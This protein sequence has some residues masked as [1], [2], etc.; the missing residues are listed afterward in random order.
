MLDLIVQAAQHE[1][2]QPSAVA[3]DPTSGYVYIGLKR[4]QAIGVFH[5]STG[6]RVKTLNLPSRPSQVAINPIQHLVYAL[7]PEQNAV[8]ILDPDQP[9]PIIAA[10]RNPG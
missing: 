7:L 10:V 8:A 1:I 5:G 4:S 6:E 3:V 2:E 9:Q